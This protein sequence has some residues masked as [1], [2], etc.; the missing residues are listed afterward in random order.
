M[1]IRPYQQAG[2][3]AIEKQYKAGI[4]QQLLTCP[5]GTGKTVIFSQIP[6]VLKHLGLAGQILILAHRK[7]LLAQ[8]S[9][10]LQQL[11]SRRNDS[12]ANAPRISRTRMPIL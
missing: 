12:V 4:H 7:E 1:S 8:A 6:T 3:D 2:L 5:T 11:E 10:K 9:D